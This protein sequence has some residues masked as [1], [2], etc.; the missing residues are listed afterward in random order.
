MFPIPLPQNRSPLHPAAFLALP[1][2]AVRP[3]GWLLD[4]LRL[5]ANG[6]TGHLDEYWPDVGLNSGWLG[7]SGEDWERGPYYCDGLLPL[8]Y[9]LDDQRLIAKANKYISWTLNSLRPNGYFGP[10][11]P[12][13]WPRMV[14]IK[15]LMA[16]YEA[17][18]DGRVLELL[19]A[20]FKYMGCMLDS[21]PLFAWASARAAD[22][23]LAL[24]W[25][26]N[27]CGDSS[28]LDLAGKIQRQGMDWP[29]LQGRYE[30]A[31]ALPLK[32]YSGNMGTHVVNHAQGIKTGAVWYVQ[33]GEDWHRQSARAGIN[34]LMQHHGQPNGMWSGDEH[35]HGTSPVQGTE[36]CAV[37][38]Y[39]YSLEE[40]ER[41]LGDP[42][43]GDILEQVAYNAFPATFKPDM[44]AHQYD[45]Q[46]NQVVCSVARRAWADNL[47]DS[48]IYGQTPNFGCCQANLH[49]GW[50]KLV[51]SLVMA[52]P[53]GGLA[54]TAWGPCTARVKL[55]DAQVR[56]EVETNYPFAGDSVLRLHLD[57][58]AA[59]PLLLRIPGW[60]GGTRI[61]SGGQ[62]FTPQAGTFFKLE[63]RWQDGDEVKVSF[64]M[65]VCV[66]RGHRG[67]VSVYRGPLLFGLK[68]GEEW[69]KV[70][71][72]E[73]HADWEVYPTTPWNYGLAIDPDCLE[74]AFEVDTFDPQA[75]PFAPENAPVVLRVNGRRLPQWGLIDN[76]AGEIDAGPHITD[77]PL[78]QLTL[79]PY[80]S[81]N[82]RIAAFPLVRNG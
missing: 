32:Q 72:E 16:Y 35:L 44:W 54:V 10:R 8:A 80:G 59:F 3:Q 79:I 74:G 66:V 63:R 60:A 25:L 36:L 40:M 43:L 77:E 13:W 11:N 58:P 57:H 71:N 4:E 21:Q 45:Q 2:G 82:L 37:A 34:N 38:E 67:L 53:G 41:I 27:R 18:E 56:L 50:P 49:Q 29:A 78:E 12:D 30:I 6:I 14:M 55:P 31:Q 15:V 7:G 68:I 69:L 9:L 46:V 70:G 47:D 48:N 19:L 52:A 81:T 1:L 73:P 26:Y 5:Q 64:P 51:R 22:N 39:M 17:A 75:V 61:E 42:S 23:L 24:H 76:S 33:S 28:L 62:I 65:A 20:Y